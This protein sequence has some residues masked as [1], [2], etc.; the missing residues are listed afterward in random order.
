MVKL[1]LTLRTML[2]IVA[3]VAILLAAVRELNRRIEDLAGNGYR[4]QEVGFLLVDYLDDCGKWPGN[5][6]DLH[7]YVE[8]H[9]STLQHVPNIGVLQS[10]VRIKFDF[11]P[12]GIALPFE[13]SDEKPPFIVVSSKYGRTT[14][15]TCNPN[16]FIF[17]YLC[18]DIRQSKLYANKKF[19]RSAP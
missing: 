7:R 13:W 17:H 5:W 18:G 1:Q 14:G 4:V 19:Q 2:I 10:H 11:D 12:N 8:S 15:A 6:D 9:R 16:E 3:A